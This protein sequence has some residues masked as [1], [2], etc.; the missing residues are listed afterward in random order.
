MSTWIVLN[1]SAALL[2]RYKAVA[3]LFSLLT[4]MCRGVYMCQGDVAIHRKVRHFHCANRP[5][6]SVL[7]EGV[8]VLVPCVRTRFLQLQ[9]NKTRAA[10]RARRDR[11]KSMVMKR[12]PR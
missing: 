6:L 8:G 5:T 3:F 7:I 10:T 12:T 11:V 2:A 9:S 1:S 4:Y